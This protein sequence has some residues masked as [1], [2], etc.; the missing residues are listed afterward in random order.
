MQFR[1]APIDEGNDKTI[2]LK[3]RMVTSDGLAV[4]WIYNHIYFTDT[5]HCTIE[6][7]NFEGTMGKIL[8][9]DNIEIPRSIALDP[10]DG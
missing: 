3:D 7:T 8:I 4:D 10:V 5:Q 6:V 9:E 2:V 1:R